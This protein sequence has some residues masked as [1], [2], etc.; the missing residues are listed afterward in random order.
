M[1]RF[2]K[3][4][5]LTFG[6][7]ATAFFGAH[8]PAFALGTSSNEPVNFLT[9]E[10][11]ADF[12]KQIERDLASERALA[13]IVFRT[14]RTRDQLPEGIDYTHGAFW[15][16]R[17]IETDSGEIVR[18]YSV[19]NL[20]HGDG[21]TLPRT[22]SYLMQDWPVD[23][24]RGTAVND[25]GVIIPS[26]EMQRRIIGIIDSPRYQA[27][28]NP[29]YSLIANPH[30][31]TYQNCNSFMLNVVAS[32][33]WLTGDSEQI[34][35]NLREHYT[36]QE[37]SVGLLARLFGPMADERIRTDDQSGRFQTATYRSMAAFMEENG[38]LQESYVIERETPMASADNSGQTAPV[39]ERPPE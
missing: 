9:L 11:A 17:A 12:S 32:A 4:A 2:L 8:S 37:F 26:P 18:G 35:A 27:L 14:G 1:T 34:A 23:F 36:P 25:V 29:N 6:A 38:L 24:T 21:E 28:H 30:E 31:P 20:Y 16:Y 19:Y 22:Q 3:T 39:F 33:A 5:I 10:E 7:A 15:V 13:A